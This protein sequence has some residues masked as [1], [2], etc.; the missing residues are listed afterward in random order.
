MI[1]SGNPVFCAAA[2]ADAGIFGVYCNSP[3]GNSAELDY[4]I[5]KLPGHVLTSTLSQSSSLSMSSS[6][7]SSSP[8]SAS[9]QDIR[10][11]DN[12]SIDTQG[13]QDTKD[14]RSIDTQDETASEFP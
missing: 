9:S 2:S 3:P 12:R 6:T 5:T 8:A 13:T 10:T 7:P 4:I 14:N 11:Q 1:R